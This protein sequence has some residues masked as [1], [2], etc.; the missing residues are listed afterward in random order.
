MPKFKKN[1][2]GF[3]MK[4]YTYPGTSPIEQD[5]HFL[6]K[7]KTPPMEGAQGGTKKKWK[8]ALD[9]D[10]NRITQD[11]AKGMGEG[12]KKGLFSRITVQKQLQDIKPPKQKKKT[13]KKRGWF[14]LPD[15]GITEALDAMTKKQKKEGTGFHKK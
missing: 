12:A 2:S 14:G 5:E 11:T 10:G 4:G 1:R 15:L 6:E 3:K 9:E 13:K 8:Y 7:K